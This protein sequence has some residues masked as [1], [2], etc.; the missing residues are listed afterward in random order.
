MGPRG[1]VVGIS[2]ALCLTW[3][4][5]AA[6][7]AP[8]EARARARRA[9]ALLTGKGF[10]G[11]P[12]YGSA[13]YVG[14]GLLLTCA[15]FVRDAPNFGSYQ[16][17]L[18]DGKQ[19]AC[20]V[21]GQDR[22]MA[23]LRVEG[24]TASGP[25]PLVFSP[26]IAGK[27]EPFEVLGYAWSGRPEEA[28]VFHICPAHI[29]DLRQ[30]RLHCNQLRAGGPAL[31]RQGRLLGLLSN[32][33]Q[34]YVVPCRALLDGLRGEATSLHF[35][36]DPGAQGATSSRTVCVTV[37]DPLRRVEA[38][39]LHCWASPRSEPGAQVPESQR[40][41]RR[42]ERTVPLAQHNEHS[43]YYAK[44]E[45]AIDPG[46]ELWCEVRAKHKGGKPP[47]STWVT[48][49]D[50]GV[51]SLRSQHEF[52]L[53][54][55]PPGPI[56]GAAPQADAPHAPRALSCRLEAEPGGRQH[57]RVD[58]PVARL[59]LDRPA[60]TLA[61]PPSGAR[62]FTLEA[63][64]SAVV[65]RD[66]L[67]LGQVDAI[68]TPRYPIALWCD[69]AHLA[70]AC[71]ESRVVRV[72]SLRDRA[73][74]QV[75]RAVGDAR[76]VPRRVLG[77]A[78]EGGWLAFWLGPNGDRQILR[79]DPSGISYPFP[80][81]LSEG[82]ADTRLLQLGGTLAIHQVSAEHARLVDLRRQQPA[83]SADHPV[84]RLARAGDYFRLSGPPFMTRDRA[85]VV[86]PL[87][88]D[89]AEVRGPWTHV[90]SPDLQT[91]RCDFPGRAVAEVTGERGY[92]VSLVTKSPDGRRIPVE[93]HYR[94][95]KSGA[96]LRRVL[97][98]NMK[99]GNL[100]ASSETCFVAEVERLVIRDG[101]RALLSIPCG[102]IPAGVEPP[103]LRARNAPPRTAAPGVPL[104]YT[105]EL[106]QLEPGAV[107]ELARGP[108]GARVDAKTGRLTWTPSRA[109]VGRWDVEI[110]VRSRGQKVTVAAWVIDV[111]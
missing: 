12:V 86:L 75:Q 21:V 9:T 11:R 36:R 110:A 82:D 29:E 54:S 94:D 106:P 98:T 85:G 56:P 46:W 42:R 60:L 4:S 100:G 51:L 8:E 79:L 41:L 38:V 68:P 89:G 28:P 90:L 25:E 39:E 52:Q 74:V 105:P 67:T 58:A 40:G 17:T 16:A 2:L 87:E 95:R 93:V 53:S 24:P 37:L 104:T 81:R 1:R 69:E 109:A 35:E 27:G 48:F 83:S 22:I 111:H 66:A 63:G 64:E 47:S 88:R 72:I 108:A 19:V 103:A 13:F 6:A 78:L 102:P 31:D 32:R 7:Q 44:L 50:P 30:V 5:A 91:Q 18:S 20:K 107:F 80:Y 57:V 43:S 49:H 59:Q 33:V 70:V 76:W 96:L 14:P 99:V 101:D 61:A 77:A 15:S 3:A 97:P 10:R 55:T 23:F 62:F 71:D 65:V 34:H 73:P 45:L 26:S 92:F 84:L